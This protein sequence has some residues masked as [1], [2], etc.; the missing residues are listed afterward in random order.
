M[1]SMDISHKFYAI[2]RVMT[3]WIVHTRTFTIE[4][5]F[6][7][8]TIYRLSIQQTARFDFTVY[9]T[10]IQRIFIKSMS[11]RQHLCIYVSYIFK[12]TYIH[13][14]EYLPKSA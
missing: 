4:R 6:R 9:F 1:H 8:V 10:I 7:T 3:I 12:N 11:K 5:R 13:R 2:F 14:N